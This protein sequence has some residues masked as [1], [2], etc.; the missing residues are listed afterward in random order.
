VRYDTGATLS[1][2]L[3]AYSPGEG[4]RVMV[5]GTAG[6]LELD[7]QE[8]SYVS[9]RTGDPNAPGAGDGLAVDQARLTLRPLWGA[10]RRVP[11]DE[12]ASGHGGGDARLLADLF[13]RPRAPD[14]LGRAATHLDGARAMLVG[15]AANRSFATGAPVRIADLIP[16]DQLTPP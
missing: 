4:Y 16:A 6:R 13:G 3:T 8:R 9:G 11:L 15:V 12:G 10:P 7:V 1:Y 14:P 2:H 5:N